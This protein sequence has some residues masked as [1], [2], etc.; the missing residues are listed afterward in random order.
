[1]TRVP[2]PT[3]PSVYSKLFLLQPILPWCR[4]TIGRGFAGWCP[5]TAVGSGTWTVS[6]M[7]LLD[8]QQTRQWPILKHVEI[9]S[10]A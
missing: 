7:P 4:L 1:M 9:C 8:R 2:Q 3:D 6:A 5:R 10:S